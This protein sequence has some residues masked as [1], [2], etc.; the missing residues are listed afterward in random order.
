[1]Q[2]VLT[3]FTHDMGF[4]VF[5]FERIGEDRVRRR[6]TVRTDLALIRRYGIRLQELPLMCR[7][8]LE[9]RDEA[10][11][12]RT[13]TFTE[14]EMCVYARDTAAAREAAAQKRKPPRK[15]ATEN[16]GAAW[17]APQL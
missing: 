1:M 14:S 11:D 7:S 10:E 2:F 4:R 6:F 3:G 15:P 16:I 8:I 17:R 5:A 12:A 9:Q 13:L